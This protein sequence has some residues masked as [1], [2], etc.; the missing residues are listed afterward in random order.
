[1]CIWSLIDT[2]HKVGDFKLF[3]I[4]EPY[5]VFLS[6]YVNMTE[7]GVAY[8]EN[9]SIATYFYFLKNI[10]KIFYFWFRLRKS[11][12]EMKNLVWKFLSFHSLPCIFFSLSLSSFSFPYCVPPP[13][14]SL[15]P[16]SLLSC[17]LIEMCSFLSKQEYSIIHIIFKLI[18]SFK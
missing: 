5:I 17:F 7:V 14:S 1:M 3:S 15:L 10:P 16:H 11:D 12:L 18:A 9:D 6:L 13:F 2:K 4:S 8:L